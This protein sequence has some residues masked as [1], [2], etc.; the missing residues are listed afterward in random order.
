[1]SDSFSLAIMNW[2]KEF[3]AKSCSVSLK[4]GSKPEVLQEIVRGLVK[5][6]Q[7]PEA[8][9]EVAFQAL[10]DREQLASTG[11][12]MNVAIPHVKLPGLDKAICSLGIHQEGAEWGAVDGAPVKI[13]FTVLRPAEAG[14]L[15]DPEQHL[16]MMRWIAKLGRDGDFRSFAIQ[17]KTKK[18]LVDLLK[19]MR[20]A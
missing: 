9:E 11:V 12:G 5:T 3:K 18:E 1:M 7:L 10:V 8:L 17:A 19:E 4:A 15:H 20:T 6:D 2:W 13:L 14:E 16:E